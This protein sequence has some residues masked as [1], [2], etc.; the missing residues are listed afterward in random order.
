MASLMFVFLNINS[1]NAQDEKTEDEKVYQ[2]ESTIDIPHTSVKNQYRSGTCWS[3][4]GLGMLEAELIRTDKGEYDLSEMFIV[5]N[6]YSDKAKKYVRLHGSLNMSGGGGFSDDVYVM[7]KFGL[8]PEEVYEGLEIGEEKHV[9][10][11]MDAV[12]KAY[13]DAVIKNKNR[14]LTPVWHEGFEGM[15]N[16]YLGDYPETFTYNG[17]EYTPISFA[18]ELGLNADDYVEFTSYTHV[19]FYKPFIM[20]IPDNWIWSETYNLPLDE[21][22]GVIDHALE[23]GYTIAWGGDVSEK[24]FSWKNGVAIVPASNKEVLSGTEKEKWEALTTSERKKAMYKFEEIVPEKV[25]TQQMRQDSYNNYQLTDDH[26][27]LIVGKAK[28]QKGN[29]YYKVKNSWGTDSHVYD[30]Y[31]YIS[32]P[33]IELNTMN[34]MVNKDAVSKHLKKELGL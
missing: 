11:E 2:F 25:I 31:I 15:L 21:M 34:F 18:E 23:Q 10:G 3:F 28:D 17:I 5:R 14:K 33:F 8:V 16:A 20:Q 19:P 32:K 1:T 24:G 27:M 9:H 13:T 4:S 29:I 22:M 7:D 12:F 30:G 6:A 26:G